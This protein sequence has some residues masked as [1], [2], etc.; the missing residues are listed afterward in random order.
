MDLVA[1]I[2]LRERDLEREQ[3]V[4]ESLYKR[5]KLAAQKASEAQQRALACEEAAKLLA[6]FADERQEQ[7]I[8]TIE[9]ITSTGLTQIFGTPI[10][11]KLEQVVRARR[12][13]MD[14]KI[15]SDGLETSIMD[16]R[17][18]GLASVAGFLLRVSVLL[19]TRNAR[20]LMVLDETFAMLSEEYLANMAEFLKQLSEQ[21]DMQII[22]VTHQSELLESADKVIRLEKVQGDVHTKEEI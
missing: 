19:L 22:L 1:Q 16:A 9:T 7:V 17:G 20:R 6:T 5:Q 14:A 4:M 13:E 18:G 8:G 2:T 10:Q 21:A 3:G 12:V 15:V 11:L